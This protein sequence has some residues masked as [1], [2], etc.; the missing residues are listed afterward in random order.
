MK[1]EMESSVNLIGEG[2]ST[3][4]EKKFFRMINQFPLMVSTKSWDN[5]LARVDLTKACEKYKSTIADY[6]HRLE[7]LQKKKYLHGA[8]NK[9]S[10]IRDSWIPGEDYI[11]MHGEDYSDQMF[12]NYSF[13]SQC[14]GEITAHI[15]SLLDL[16]LE[17]TETNLPANEKPI[18]DNHSNSTTLLVSNFIFNKEAIPDTI[19]CFKGYFSEPQLEMLEDS[20]ISGNDPEEVLL[21][22]GPGNGCADAFKQLYDAGVITGCQKKGLEAW[23]LRNIQYYYNRQIKSYTPSYLNKIIS[24]K[25]DNTCQNPIMNIHIDKSTNKCKISRIMKGE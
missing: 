2:F 24:G 15:N 13:V 23:I 19:E 7:P 25:D 12:S 11:M 8:L 4:C 5:N 9:I 22:L 3:K 21:Y 1:E 10:A 17:E 6:F 20:L 14:K 16:M 18:G